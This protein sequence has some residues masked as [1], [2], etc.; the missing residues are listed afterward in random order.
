M[1]TDFKSVLKNNNFLLIWTSQI[2]SQ[3]TINIMNFIL[4][5]RLFEETGSAIAI[6]LLWVTYALPAILVGP[7]ASAIVD[8]IDR[9]KMLMVTNFLQALTI[10]F[11]ALSH[12]FSSFLVYEVVFIYSLLN[13]FY[14]PAESATLPSVLPKKKLT[15]GN[16]LFFITMQGSLILGYGVAGALKHFL[17]FDNTLYLGAGFLFLAFLS[18]S[19]L[20]SLKTEQKVVFDL[21]T[22]IKS[23][24]GHIIEGYDFIRGKRTVYM[25]FLL[26]ISFQAILAVVIVTIPVFVSQII[27]GN[28]N[29]A[30][31][32][33]VVPAAIGALTGAVNLPKLIAKGWR[34]KKIIESSLLVLF[35]I[36]ST[37]VFLIPYL[38]YSLRA[39]AA[40]FAVAIAGFSFVGV[41]IPCQTFLQ[42]TTPKVLLGRVFGNFWFLTT[43]VSVFPVVFSGTIIELLGVKFLLLILAGVSLFAY[44]VSRKYGDDWLKK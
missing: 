20:P 16:S 10:L 38:N 6:S 30:G 41:I 36:M 5:I 8:M 15:Y 43:V 29:L 37:L 21:E 23:F 31:V 33:L 27:K 7:I 18:V 3:L 9:R 17:G 14:I 1:V 42:E 25:P 12:Q 35:I 44:F 19:R 32:Y 24:F 28:L 2:L 34:K 4:L 11:F 40:F 13:Q 22:G 39:T 26:L